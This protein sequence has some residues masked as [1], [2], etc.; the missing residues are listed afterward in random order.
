[1]GLSFH[2]LKQALST[3]HCAETGDTSKSFK[4]NDGENQRN[5]LLLQK[6]PK[7]LAE[8]DKEWVRELGALFEIG[9]RGSGEC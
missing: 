3:K 4:M 5:Q 2:L 8:C 7:H 1:M 9:G 6:T